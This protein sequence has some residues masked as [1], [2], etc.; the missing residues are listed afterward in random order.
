[1]LAVIKYSFVSRWL[2]FKKAG[3]ISKFNFSK[4]SIQLF[5]IEK[6]H[7]PSIA[8]LQCRR[9]APQFRQSGRDFACV[10]ASNY[11]ANQGVRSGGGYAA[12]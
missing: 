1:V 2:N 11:H 10:R 8:G 12:V 7:F 5:L 3:K 6:R 9:Q 4:L